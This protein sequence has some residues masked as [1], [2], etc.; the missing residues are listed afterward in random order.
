MTMMMFQVVHIFHSCYHSPGGA[1]YSVALLD[2][3][4]AGVGFIPDLRTPVMSQV[5]KYFRAVND[6]LPLVLVAGSAIDLQTDM[7][8]EAARAKTGKRRK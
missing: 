8:V 4:L 7:R 6:K 1:P 3:A 5:E 2:G